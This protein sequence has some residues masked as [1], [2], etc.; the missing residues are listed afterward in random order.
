[1]KKLLTFLVFLGS[2]DLTASAWK[3][4][5]Y[6]HQVAMSP[7]CL[8]CHVKDEVPKQG[9]N[10]QPH[11]M[12]I[13]GRSRDLGLACTGCHQ[14]KNFDDAIKPPGAKGWQLPPVEMGFDDKTTAQ[15]L[16]EQWTNPKTNGEKSLEDLLAHAKTDAM[17]IWSWQP[18]GIRMPAPGS[19]PQFV[20][21]FEDWIQAGAP[22]QEEKL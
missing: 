12:G 4:F 7:R 21:H 5:E 3:S 11:I 9:E 13:V 17:V 1:M 8:N 15:E 6:V 18:G 16:C 20:K 2:G 22:C 19:H 14:D 10:G